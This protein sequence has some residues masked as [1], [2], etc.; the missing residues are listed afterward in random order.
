MGN[1]RSHNFPNQFAYKKDP[2]IFIF[3][4]MAIPRMPEHSPCTL[5]PL[6]LVL[7][8]VLPNTKS[9]LEHFYLTCVSLIYP[10]GVLVK[11]N[12]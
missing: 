2:T 3:L 8:D 1:A 6:E 9:V 7:E 12:P 5:F 10:Q 4:L 11:Q